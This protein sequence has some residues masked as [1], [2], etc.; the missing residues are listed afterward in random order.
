M[1]S[2][3]HSLISDTRYYRREEDDED[4]D[5]GPVLSQQ[6]CQHK[7]VF[8]IRVQ[9]VT[10]WKLFD[11]RRNEWWSTEPK[12]S[13]LS[14]SYDWVH[15]DAMAREYPPVS[16]SSEDYQKSAKDHCEVSEL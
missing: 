2:W 15:C 14:C 1:E 11:V 9:L 6:K 13:R 7:W 16:Y 4:D 10:L 12:V 8:C 3:I 5:S